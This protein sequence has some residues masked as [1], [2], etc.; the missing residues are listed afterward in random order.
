MKPPVVVIERHCNRNQCGIAVRFK[1]T[2][3][4]AKTA[5]SSDT[6][7]SLKRGGQWLGRTHALRLTVSERSQVTE[8]QRHVSPSP[9]MLSRA[10]NRLWR[11]VGRTTSI[12][13]DQHRA[14]HACAG[15]IQEE[16][17][18]RSSCRPG[19][20]QATRPHEGRPATT[21]RAPAPA[22][23]GQKPLPDNLRVHRPPKA[24]NF[25]RALP[26]FSHGARVA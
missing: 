25:D 3:S 2:Q 1:K 24:C 22:R 15:L 9:K 8:R 12:Q 17:G 23:A 14:E 19:M 5:Q 4:V 18:P 20:A 6:A 10:Q 26:P 11:S 16:H 21:G 7:P 13:P